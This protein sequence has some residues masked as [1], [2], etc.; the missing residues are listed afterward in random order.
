MARTEE[1]TSLI[2]CIN[3]TCL[4]D[5]SDQL[6]TAL[7]EKLADSNV[8][9]KTEVCLGACGLGPNMVLY[10]RGTWLSPVQMTDI[11]DIVSHI[12]GGPV[13]ERLLN[14]VEKD[15]QEMILSV[16]DAAN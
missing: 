13:P 11:D 9:V 8:Q 5:G 10:P 1:V 7:K 16:L 15:L 12:K 2:V 14:H 3:V 6:V 4:S